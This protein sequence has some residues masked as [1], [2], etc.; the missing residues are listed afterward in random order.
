M[1]RFA[2][3]SLLFTASAYIFYLIPMLRSKSQPT[4]STWLSWL[5]MDIAIFCAMLFGE[6]F[7]IQMMT[8]VLGSTVVIVVC[9]F[10]KASLGWQLL[11]TICVSI[12]A[13]AIG[14]WIV[15]G[16]ETTAIILSLIA[17]TVGS[18]P[19][20]VNTWR[21][22]RNES[23]LPWLVVFMGGIFQ[24]LSLEEWTLLSSSAS[25]T[26]LVLQITFIILISR[27]YFLQPANA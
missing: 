25:F 21:N 17:A 15:S 11:D 13:V 7:S 14:M 8:F 16:D 12:V 9:Y 1:N 19:M 24:L 6:V 18:I 4:V 3:L 5:A 23:I 20:M 26:F 27:K 10:K 2:L 22:P